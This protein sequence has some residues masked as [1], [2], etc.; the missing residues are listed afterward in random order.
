RL[1]RHELARV[2]R[3]LARWLFAFRFIAIVAVLVVLSARPVVRSSA[4]ETIPGRVLVAVDVSDSMRV[5]DPP[6]TTT[7][8]D[9][10][11]LILNPQGLDLLNRLRKVHTV[12]PLAFGQ[13]LHDL[14][15]QPE[16]LREALAA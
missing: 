4:T 3:R 14:P 8:L 13:T 10:T 5:T 6:N 12:Q 11:A 15:S 7:R 16:A 2:R 9:R 1:Y